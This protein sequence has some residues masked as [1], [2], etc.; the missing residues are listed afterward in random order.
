MSSSETQ[1]TLSPKAQAMAARLLAVQAIYQ[2]QQ[3]QKPVSALV[4]EYMDH[5]AGMD[6]DGQ[7]MVTPDG[8]LLKNIIEGVHARHKELAA[9]I[10]AHVKKSEEG[11]SRQTEPLLLAILLAGTYELLAHQDTDFPVIINDYLNVTHAF[12]DKMEAGLVNGILDPIARQL[13]A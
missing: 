10:D 9:I 12:Y 5:R 8:V 11:K 1:Q 7:T 13:R 4:K 6:V 2:N 3:N